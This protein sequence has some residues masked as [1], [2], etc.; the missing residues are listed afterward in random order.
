MGLLSSGGNSVFRRGRA[1]DGMLGGLL[2]NLSS[3][4]PFLTIEA[5]LPEDLSMVSPG[6]IRDPP[7]LSLYPVRAV[8]SCF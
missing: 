2:Y 3:T 6:G 8:R 5:L 4:E 7:Y 1:A